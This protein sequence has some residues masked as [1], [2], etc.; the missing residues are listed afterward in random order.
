MR[1]PAGVILV[2]DPLV[3]ADGPTP[4]SIWAASGGTDLGVIEYE[5]PI[6]SLARQQLRVEA[7]C[8]SRCSPSVW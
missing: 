6:E 1:A 8:P 5:M 4:E 2:K 3:P 7:I